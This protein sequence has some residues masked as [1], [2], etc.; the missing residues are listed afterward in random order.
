MTTDG[1][2]AKQV[3]QGELEAQINAAKAE[4]EVL[5]SREEGTMLKAEVEAY[6]TLM[7]KLQAI[8]QKMQELK[9][10]TGA[11][12]KQ[13]K[14]DLR[15]PDQRF[16]EIGER[17]RVGCRSRLAKAHGE[18]DL[19]LAVCGRKARELLDEGGQDSNNTAV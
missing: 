4:L 3:I 8:Q 1:N 17:D 11:Q 12:W 19:N 14:A 2:I 7:P 15:S 16:Q 18:D 5:E 6:E 13:T 10:S 9:K